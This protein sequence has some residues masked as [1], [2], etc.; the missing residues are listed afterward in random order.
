M[1]ILGIGKL[2]FF[3]VRIIVML[4]LCNRLWIGIGNGVIIFVFFF[5]SK[6]I[7]FV[8]YKLGIDLVKNV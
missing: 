1:I 5:E 2:G 8:E 7:I 4:I 3:F 6:L